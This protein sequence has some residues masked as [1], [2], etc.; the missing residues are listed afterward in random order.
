MSAEHIDSDQTQIFAHLTNEHIA[1]AA[2]IGTQLRS[3]SFV[4]IVET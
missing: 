2:A 3:T 1:N 4:W